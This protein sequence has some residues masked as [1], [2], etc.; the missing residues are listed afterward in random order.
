MLQ[1][2]LIIYCTM[3]KEDAYNEKKKRKKKKKRH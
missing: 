3:G 2:F 1:T